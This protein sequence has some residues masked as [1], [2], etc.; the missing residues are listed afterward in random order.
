[1]GKCK[2]FSGEGLLRLLFGMKNQHLL[3]EDR[4]EALEAVQELLINKIRGDL[5]EIKIEESCGNQKREC[6]IV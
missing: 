1:M 2:S 6:F 4:S 5:I 3:E